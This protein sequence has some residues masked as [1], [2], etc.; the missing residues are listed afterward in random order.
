M[1]KASNTSATLKKV[2]RHIKNYRHLL[3]VSILLAAFTVALTL[4][5]PVLI[6]DAMIGVSLPEGD[7]TLVFTYQNKAFSLGWKI[8]L[9]CAA[10]FLGLAAIAYKPKRKKGKFEK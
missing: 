7:H 9:L 2:L 10:L 4:Y 8:S 3:F 6:G 5:I 1:K